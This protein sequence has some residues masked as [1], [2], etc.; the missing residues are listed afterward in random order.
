MKNKTNEI[1][2]ELSLDEKISLLTGTESMSTAGIERLGIQGKK[3]ADGPHGVRKKDGSK[4]CTAFP[5]LCS[6]G[7]AWDT[8][9]V[10]KMGVSLAKEC[11]FHDIDILLAPGVNIKRH[12]LCGRN[13]E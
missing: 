9:L 5:N 4:D 12:I 2:K 13:F 7:A 3:M 6:V 10:Y 8:E 11:I 1:L